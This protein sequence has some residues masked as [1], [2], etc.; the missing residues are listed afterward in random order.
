[1]SIEHSDM[2]H[3]TIRFDAF[4]LDLE[5]QRLIGASGPLDLR[6]KC[7]DV[8][9]YLAEHAGRVVS[10]NELHDA[11][12]P[13]VTVTD[14]SLTQCISEIRR[15]IGDERRQVIK[16]IPRRGY[17]LDT[18]V[19][20]H[21]AE[22]SNVADA[23]QPGARGEHVTSGTTGRWL[24]GWTLVPATATALVAMAV[25]IGVKKPQDIQG[26]W[27]GFLNCEKLPF[28][29]GPFV[30]AP[31]ELTVSGNSAVYARKVY[32]PDTKAAVDTERGAGTVTEDGTLNITGHFVPESA[33]YSYDA[34]YTGRLADSAAT[35]GGTHQFQING[36]QYARNCTVELERKKQA[37]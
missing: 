13:H 20:S 17:L 3:K 23:P 2:Q 24:V 10:K 9:R 14:E 32:S 21:G 27:R 28:T 25:V 16:T 15:A 30:G 11:V 37:N 33:K 35:L 7:F 12:W 5:R 26:S 31:F 4:T 18:P 36:E 19:E 29:Q 8:L 22:K 6:P 1:M 34:S